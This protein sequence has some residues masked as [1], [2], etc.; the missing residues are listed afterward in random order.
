M[1]VPVTGTLC[2]RCKGSG[3]M[4]SAQSILEQELGPSPETPRLCTACCGIGWL[5]LPTPE[6]LLRSRKVEDFLRRKLERE[7]DA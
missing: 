7:S 2:N 5:H 3:M 4:T 6:N 1:N